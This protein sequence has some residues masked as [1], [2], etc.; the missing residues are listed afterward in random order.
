MKIALIG[1]GQIGQGVYNAYR[2]FFEYDFDIYDLKHDVSVTHKYIDVMLV[3]IPYTDDFIETI[4]GYQKHLKPKA[5]IIFSTVAVGTT[6]QIPNAVHVPIEGKHPNLAESIKQWQ[7]FMGGFNQIAY[8]FFVQAGKNPY[9]LE[10][11][12]HTEFLKLQS[13][14]NYGLMIEYARY[15]NSVCKEIGMDYKKVQEYD[16]C[17]SNLYEGMDMP[18]FRRYILTPPEGSK[19]GHCVTNNAL[20]L[21]EQFPDKLIDIVAEVD[22]HGLD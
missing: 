15:V 10:K 18:Q 1:F 4:S 6:S 3:A 2:P 17:Y 8:D 11:P 21:K 13:T 20:I 19:G 14:T 22:I 12:E 9:I 5:T 16:A 7:V